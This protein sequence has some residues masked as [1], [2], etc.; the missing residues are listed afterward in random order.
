MR[1]QLNDW[2]VD[3]LRK[4]S[5][6]FVMLGHTEDRVGASFI[7]YDFDAAMRIA[8]DHLVALG[9]RHI[10]YVSAMPS[11]ESQHGPTMRALRA[12]AKPALSSTFLASTTADHDLRHIRLMTTNCCRSI[13]RSRRS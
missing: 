13:L 2:R 8:L 12:Y 4:M 5:L 11:Q 6:P 10:G 3:F 1:V 9:H 7:D